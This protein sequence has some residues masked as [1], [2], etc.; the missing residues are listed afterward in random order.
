MSTS[1]QAAVNLLEHCFWLVGLVYTE[2]GTDS[3]G[4][5]FTLLL[6]L[7]TVFTLFKNSKNTVGKSKMK[8]FTFYPI[9]YLP[10]TT[11][12]VKNTKR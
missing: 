11:P 3:T 5:V 2:P 7:P 10:F 8:S 9:Y 6:L 1:C 12:R 4:G